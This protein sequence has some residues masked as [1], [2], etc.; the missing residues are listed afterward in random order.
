MVANDT[1][2]Q[3]MLDPDA[4]GVLVVREQL[5]FL[6]ANTFTV[7]PRRATFDLVT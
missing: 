5:A 1:S 4:S 3:G 7:P 6:V 2:R